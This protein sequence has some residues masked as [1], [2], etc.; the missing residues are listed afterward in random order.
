MKQQGKLQ[1]C[2]FMFLD[3]KW[4]SKRFRAERYPTFPKFNLIS[5]SSCMQFGFVQVVPKSWNFATYSQE[6]LPANML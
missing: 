3:G 6:L 2:I 1:V 4:E 5:V